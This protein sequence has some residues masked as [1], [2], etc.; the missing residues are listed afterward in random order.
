MS[1]KSPGKAVIVNN[2]SFKWLRERK[3]SDKDTADLGN[4]LQRLRFKTEIHKDLNR[5]KLQKVFTDVSTEDHSDCDCLIFCIM[6]HGDSGGKIHCTDGSLHLDDLMQD[7]KG[8]RC[9]SLAGKPKVFVI[10]V[11]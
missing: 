1:H 5:V 7:F 3:G 10:Q 2:V 4:A 9:K 6:T 11:K 8:D